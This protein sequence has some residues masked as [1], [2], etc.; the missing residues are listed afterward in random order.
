MEV[1][2]KLAT[3]HQLTSNDLH[4]F[5]LA[6]F[7]RCTKIEGGGTATPSDGSGTVSSTAN[8]NSNSNSHNNANH[9]A[10]SN[11]NRNNG[12]NATNATQTPA[13]SAVPA[14]GIIRNDRKMVRLVSVFLQNL[15]SNGIVRVEDFVEVQ[16][17]CIQNSRVRE[18][19]A[20]FKLIKDAAG[21]GRKGG[22]IVGNNASGSG[23]GG[24][25]GSGNSGGGR[26]N[27]SGGKG[28]KSGRRR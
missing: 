7:E 19:N 2:Y 23:S 14:T 18:A 26:K 17:F 28:G 13:V 10:N 15:I 11:D 22:K 3:N 20:L 24:G 12:T 16:A 9:N 25:S 5:V 21:R 8:V 1:V 6:L 4:T 27:K